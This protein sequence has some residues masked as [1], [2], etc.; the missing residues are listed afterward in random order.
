MIR[1]INHICYSVSNLNESIYFYK[2]ILCGDLLLIGKTTAYF[3]IGGLWVALNEEKDIPRN[4][5]QYSYTHTAFTIDESEYNSWY[6]WLKK[7]NVNIL[8]GRT[9]DVRDKKSIYFIDPDG[10]KLESHTGTL[11]NRMNY[12]KDT[13]PHMVFYK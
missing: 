7:N 10:H 12:Y 5:I 13:K 9:R 1:S 3:D 8:E 2:D 6:R 4:E 11:E